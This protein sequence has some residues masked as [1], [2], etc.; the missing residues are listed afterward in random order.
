MFL[1]SISSPLFPVTVNPEEYVTILTVSTV[2]VISLRYNSRTWVQLD[3]VI[4]NISNV[5]VSVVKKIP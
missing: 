1:K 4:Y 2:V 3:G 5:T